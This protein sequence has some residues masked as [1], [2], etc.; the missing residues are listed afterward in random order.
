VDYETDNK[1][2]NTI[3]NEFKNRTILCIARAFLQTRMIDLYLL[4]THSLD[5][6]RTII[7][8]DRICVLDAGVIAVSI[9]VIM[10][11]IC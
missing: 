9:F 7:G 2:Q 3:A 4:K 1:I 11:E 8:Y 10:P 5:R 6:L